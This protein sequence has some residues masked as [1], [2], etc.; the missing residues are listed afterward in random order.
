L[1]VATLNAPTPF[2]PGMLTIPFVGNC[3]TKSDDI[4]CRRGR[5]KDRAHSHNRV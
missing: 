2:V 5:D 1:K 3:R 4:G